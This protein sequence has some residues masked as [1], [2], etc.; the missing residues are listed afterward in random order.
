MRRDLGHARLRTI[1]A[2]GTVALPMQDIAATCRCL[3]LLPLLHLEEFMRRF[4][5]PIIASIALLYG[6]AP[7]SP[8]SSAPPP[9]RVLAVDSD[10]TVIRRASDDKARLEFAAPM[11]KVWSALVLAYSELG[12]QPTVSARAE[13]HYGNTGFV[14]PKRVGTRPIG[15]FFQCGSG[16]AGP[17]VDA[18]RLTANVLTSI[19][20]ASDGSTTGTTRV[21][22]TLRRNEGAS[23]DPIVCA[24]TGAIEEHI[25]KSIVR[26]LGET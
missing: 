26:R 19:R 24:S 7:A 1:V 4:A 10:G 13:G 12:I 18:G 17:Y 2:R 8:S 9:V 25:R 16:M 23:A 22:G 14:M 6:C 20:S 21:T 11:D 5:I 15:D 3:P